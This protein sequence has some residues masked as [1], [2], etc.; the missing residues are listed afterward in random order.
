MS[1]PGP[2]AT[3]APT[4]GG[5]ATASGP[6]PCQDP[7]LRDLLARFEV[8]LLHVMLDFCEAALC[9]VERTV[10]V[11]VAHVRGAMVVPLRKHAERLAALDEE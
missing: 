9:E 8:P 3:A 10:G 5:G 2:S 7:R 1:Q 4:A 6:D 11:S